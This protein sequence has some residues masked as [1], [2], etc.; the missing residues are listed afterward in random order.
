MFPA[1]VVEVA[2][3]VELAILCKYIR[4]SVFAGGSARFG[5]KSLGLYT[6][7]S[8]SK[9]LFVIRVPKILVVEDPLF[10]AALSEFAHNMLPVNLGLEVV[11]Y[12]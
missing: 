3:R 11:L 1:A 12:V 4:D 8:L 6:S 7:R 9:S 2:P 5:S 10:K